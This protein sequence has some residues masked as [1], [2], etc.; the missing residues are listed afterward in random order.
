MLKSL[1]EEMDEE[2][3]PQAYGGPSTQPLY[4]SKHEVELRKLVSSLNDPSA[5]GPQANGVAEV[6]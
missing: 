3:I 1:S 6:S 4:D 2:L 5:K